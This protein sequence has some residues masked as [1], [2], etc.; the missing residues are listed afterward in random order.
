MAQSYSAYV[1]TC[2][3]TSKTEVLLTRPCPH[4]SAVAALFIKLLNTNAVLRVSTLATFA[5]NLRQQREGT[6]A[7]TSVVWRSE[8]HM[9]QTRAPAAC[10]GSGGTDARAFVGSAQSTG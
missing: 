5:A 4:Y 2:R 10:V 6:C 3:T 8:Q 9:E 7:Q 1:R